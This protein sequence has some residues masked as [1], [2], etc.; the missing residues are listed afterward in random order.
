MQNNPAEQEQQHTLQRLETALRQLYTVYQTLRTEDRSET[1]NTS[2]MLHTKDQSFFAQR[3]KDELGEL[4]GVQ[5]GTHK[6][7][8]RQADTV[9]E[10]SQVSYWLFLLAALRNIPY[11]DFLPHA[12]LLHGYT[13][14]YKA[15]KVASLRDECLRQILSDDLVQFNRALI[16]G[17]SLVGWACVSAGISPLAPAEYDLE[18]MRNKGLL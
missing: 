3:L 2:R 6:H 17:F 15:A 10:G 4:E 18:Q 12:S 11:D 9:L 16:Q 1:S 13:G 5:A 8:G 7:K 14:Q